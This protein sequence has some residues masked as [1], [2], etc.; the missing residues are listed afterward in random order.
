MKINPFVIITLATTH[1][2][3]A[4]V[5]YR[6]AV[7]RGW[8]D[9]IVLPDHPTT[10]FD[11]V[12]D[13][14]TIVIDGVAIHIRGVDAPELGPWA[15]CWAEAIAARQSMKVLENELRRHDYRMV[16]RR[17]DKDDKVSARFIA[18]GK[19]DISD[20]M[21]VDEAGAAVD[22]RWDWCGTTVKLTPGTDQPTRAPNLWWP[23]G[24]VYD[25]RAAD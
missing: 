5:A 1:I 8:D 10:H 11:K 12:L 13:G 7:T 6:M 20:P 16:E 24:N 19:Y 3:I 9:T 14:D 15:K 18:E 25:P 17:V 23:S 22:G 4:A 2:L 21:K